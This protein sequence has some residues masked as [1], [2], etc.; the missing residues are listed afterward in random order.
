[1]LINGGRPVGARIREALEILDRIGPAGS[2]DVCR[3]M[4]SVEFSNAGK[5]CHRAVC[6]G[7]M[8]V[9]RSVDPKRFAVVSDWREKVDAIRPH[10]RRDREDPDAGRVH[11]DFI[12]H[13]VWGSPAH[14]EHKGTR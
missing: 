8:T 3:Q 12:L 14:A 9:D 7:L 6:L 5:Y 10:H 2:G 4:G 11:T 1:M 13:S